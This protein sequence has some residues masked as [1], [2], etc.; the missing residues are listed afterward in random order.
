MIT[1]ADHARISEAIRAAEA[2]TRGEIVCVLARGSSAYAQVSVLWAAA[3]ALATPW[4]LILLTEWSVQRIFLVQ[5]A[6]FIACT[7]VFSWPPIRMSLV[8]RPVQRARAHREAMEQFFARGLLTHTRGRCGVLIFV[9][10]AER[11]ARVVADEGIDSLVPADQWRG[12]I[13]ELV[14][15]MRRQSIADGF[16]AAVGLTGAILAQKAPPDGPRDPLPDR[17]YLI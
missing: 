3:V 8:P 15:H 6:V 9:S 2:T 12:V 7:L 14:A 11:Y 10:L 17:L 16:V 13:D 5:I 1:H 4:P